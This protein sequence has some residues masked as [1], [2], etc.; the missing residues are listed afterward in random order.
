MPA[1]MFPESRPWENTFSNEPVDALTLNSGVNIHFTQKNEAQRSIAKRMARTIKEKYHESRHG[2]TR[3][4]AA[5]V[6]LLLPPGPGRSAA[7]GHAVCRGPPD[8][9]G[10]GNRRERSCSHCGPDRKSVV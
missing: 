5:S 10:W 8:Y 7:D 1:G 3:N 6:P 9:P 2:P 4:P